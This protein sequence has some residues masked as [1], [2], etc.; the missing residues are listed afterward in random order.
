ML[1]LKTDEKLIAALA[2]VM[3]AIGLFLW[4]SHHGKASVQAKW[5][6]AKV[7]QLSTA[8]QLQA[9]A[10]AKYD[11]QQAK[12]TSIEHKYQDAIN[13]KPPQ[14]ADSVTAGL[15]GG[16]LRLRSAAVCAG[17]GTV[18]TATA[19]SRAA[20]EAATQALADRT[21]AAIAAVRAGDAADTREREID[22]QVIG[23][24]GVVRL[25]RAGPA[26]KPK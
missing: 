8:V 13:E 22:A 14:V 9:K 4:G 25:D 16:T 20:D 11:S 24:Q 12:L 5:D 15:H 18:S 21:V 7:I 1:D 17:A 23:L 10:D 26:D 3:L 19:R 2:I 6:A